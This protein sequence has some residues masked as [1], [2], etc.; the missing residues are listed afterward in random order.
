[1]SEFIYGIISDDSG[2]Y[3]V[4]PLPYDQKATTSLKW[5]Y[6]A[7]DAQI[8]CDKL[9]D[10]RSKSFETGK[11]VKGLGPFLPQ[12]KGAIHEKLM[13]QKN[14][15]DSGQKEEDELV[16]FFKMSGTLDFIHYLEKEGYEIVRLEKH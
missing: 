9:N 11:N 6:T 10:E 7:E 5:F 3:I 14:K 15:I 8:R 12:F 4:T 16:Q 13:E 1:M 2:R